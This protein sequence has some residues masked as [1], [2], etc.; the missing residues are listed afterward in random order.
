[1]YF[2]SSYLPSALTNARRPTGWHGESGG[3]EFGGHVA[4]DF[5]LANGKHVTTH[6]VYPTDEAYCGYSV[7]YVFL[8]RI[9]TLRRAERR[10]R[11]D[12]HDTHLSN[13]LYLHAYTLT[14]HMYS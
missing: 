11:F 13:C 10:P 4:V 6:H 3:A 2:E 5:F 14:N 9:P 8:I 12:H 7:P 1:M